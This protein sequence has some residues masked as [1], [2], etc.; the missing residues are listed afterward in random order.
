MKNLIILLVLVFVASN[1]AAVTV[2]TNQ[3]ELQAIANDLAGDYELGNDI[4][5]T[6]PFTSIME[7]TGTF[8]G[9][10]HIIDGLTMTTTGTRNSAIFG[11][12]VAGSEI[13]NVGMTNV[14]INYDAAADA[15]NPNYI[16]ALISDSKGLVE[17]CWLE[18][19]TIT[20][21]GATGGN[22]SGSLIGANRGT[23]I[24]SNCYVSGITLSIEGMQGCGGFVNQSAG[25][26]ITNCY[27]AADSVNF[28]PRNF[29]GFTAGFARDS[30]APE[31][32]NQI[33]SCYYNM[34]VTTATDGTIPETYFPWDDGSGMGRTTDPMKTQANYEGWDFAGT[35]F[36][37]E[38]Q[39]YPTLVPVVIDPN[40]PSV[41]AGISMI[42]WSG[43]AVPMVPNIVEAP[44]SD[45][46]NLTYLWTAEPDGI[47]DPDLDV[48]IAGA[49]T[50]N[51]SVTISKTATG[52]ATVVRMT[53]AVNNEGRAEPP[54]TD[55]LKIYVYDDACLAAEGTGSLELDPTDL[56]GNC[57]TNFLDFAVLATAW[58][59]DYTLTEPV[60]Q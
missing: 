3:A 2:I 45:W 34:D 29:S 17:K 20:V 47:G 39:G 35:W 25:G 59:D 32:P 12:T 11:R 16:G 55:I 33:T 6:G 19:G 48:V 30:S 27:I 23:G 15:T 43:Q 21:T 8:D 49:D 41:D 60:A 31:E 13:R 54:V 57:I 38:G 42:S 22:N 1:S 51:A 53:L 44:G 52:D 26:S 7:F 9:K 28:A 40:L 36:I 24:I 4:A 56:D 5:L 14:N 10:M 50:E 37:E 46:T 58:L 18:G